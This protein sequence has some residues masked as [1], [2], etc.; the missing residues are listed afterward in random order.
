MSPPNPNK[1]LKAE[2]TERSNSLWIHKRGE[3]TW[4]NTAPKTE[5]SKKIQGVMTCR[6]AGTHEW[7]PPQK[8]TLS[9][10]NQ[11]CN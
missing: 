4:Q 6:G 8:P 10:E 5:E 9:E 3:D 11:N 1:R 7:K 2:Q